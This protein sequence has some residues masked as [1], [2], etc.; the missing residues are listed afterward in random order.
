MP[1]FVRISCKGKKYL[2]QGLD[3]DRFSKNMAV[4]VYSDPIQAVWTKA[5]L[6]GEKIKWR[7][8]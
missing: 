1:N 8:F 4:V 3:F 6:V 2:L 5:Q 7:T